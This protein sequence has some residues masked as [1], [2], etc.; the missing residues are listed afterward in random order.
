M[1]FR[2]EAE[3]A[4][5]LRRREITIESSPVV[6]AAPKGSTRMELRLANGG[7]VE[8]DGL[9]LHTRT[10]LKTPF[11]SQ[12]GCE[13]EEGKLG[14]MYKTDMMKQT[15]VPGVFACGDAALPVPSVSYAVADGV[16]AGTSA[17][18]S[19]VFAGE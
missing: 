6:S 12:L 17:H 3:D 4:D 5:R 8:L 16:R 14:P 18:Q 13:L 15:T 9:F 10:H 2:S 19:L 7:L 1:L 11:A